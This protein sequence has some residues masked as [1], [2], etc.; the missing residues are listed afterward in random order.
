MIAFRRAG[1]GTRRAKRTC[2]LVAA[3]L[4]VLISCGP[5]GPEVPVQS[6]ANG[7]EPLRSAFNAELSKVRLLLLLDPT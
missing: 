4:G 2:I 7:L 1:F 5:S 6:L 3:A